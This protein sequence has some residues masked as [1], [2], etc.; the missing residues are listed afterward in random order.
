MKCNWAWMLVLAL[1]VGVTACEEENFNFG[2]QSLP[3]ELQIISITDSVS[4]YDFGFVNPEPTDTTYIYHYLK[5]DSVFNADGSFDKINVDT[6]YYEGKTA[7]LYTVPVLLLPS[8]KNRLCV[9][10]Q[11]NARWNAPVIPFAK[12]QDWI[13]NDK[14]AGIGDAIIDYNVES[15]RYGL[16][17]FLPDD[18][19]VPIRRELVTQYI[20]TRD[21]MVMYKLQFVQKSMTEE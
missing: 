12:N 1:M 3:S 9:K 11:S 10:I 6:V 14:V 16:P 18:I 17:D 8:V 13:K 15:R 2:D 19:I 7:K 5:R 20:T 21:S 4:G